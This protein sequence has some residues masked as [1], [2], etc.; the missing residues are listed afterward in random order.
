MRIRHFAMVSA[1]SLAAF[2]SAQSGALA[3]KWASEEGRFSAAGQKTPRLFFASFNAFA[4]SGL[5]AS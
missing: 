2:I 4:V 5:S 1:F 3:R